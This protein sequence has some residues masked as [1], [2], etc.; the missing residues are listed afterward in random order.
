[1]FKGRES[2]FSGK[3]GSMRDDLEA[4]SDYKLKWADEEKDKL[5]IHDDSSTIELI[6]VAEAGKYSTG[7]CVAFKGFKKTSN[8]VYFYIVRV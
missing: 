2:V 8:G 4:K 6:G 3:K 1:M 5:Q 7:M